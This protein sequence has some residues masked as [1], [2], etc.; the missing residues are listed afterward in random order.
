MTWD[1]VDRIIT[2]QNFEP[3][4]DD[5]TSFLVVLIQPA[6][7]QRIIPHA[8]FITRTVLRLLWKDHRLKLKRKSRELFHTFTGERRS[9]VAA[10][11]LFE[12]IVHEMLEEGIK[13]PIDPMVMEENNC[14]NAV[15]DKYM[16]SNTGGTK[17]WQSSAMEYVPFT[18]NDRDLNIQPLH[19]YVPVDPSHFTYNSFTFELARCAS[20]EGPILNPEDMRIYD[21]ADLDDVSFRLFLLYD[22]H[23]LVGLVARPYRIPTLRSLQSF[24]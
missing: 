18:T 13:V 14:P 2:K 11:W 17:T 12:G 6:D 20:Y 10:G 5:E 24:K 7:E 8:T 23:S 9:S 4:F 15:N 16:A 19:Y 22:V 21:K 3:K 1:D